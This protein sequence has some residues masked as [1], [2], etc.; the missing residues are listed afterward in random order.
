MRKRI[1]GARI[2]MVLTGLVLSLLAVCGIVAIALPDPSLSDIG[3]R[4]DQIAA[5]EKG[6][7]NFEFAVLSDVQKGLGSFRTLGNSLVKAD[8]AV[9]TGDMVAED[10]EEHWKLFLNFVRV[11]PMVAV[12]GNHDIEQGWNRFERFFGPVEF[13][14]GRGSCRFVGLASTDLGPFRSASFLERELAAAKEPNR[15]LFLHVPPFDWKQEGVVPRPGWEPF[16][17]LL[18][19]HRV[20]YVFCGHVHECRRLEHRGT[21][22]LL[23]GLGGDYESW[24]WNTKVHS[25]RVRVRGESVHLENVVLDPVH[26]VKSN[27]QHLAVGHVSRAFRQKP[28]LCWGGTVLLLAGLVFSIVVLLRLRERVVSS[29]EG[30]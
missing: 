25:M 2:A 11:R 10:D 13:S 23:N 30:A 20:Q 27:L 26:D 18:E 6:R 21:T 22:F 9:H 1:W 3:N 7:S 15:F 19:R 17:E 14:F 12:P 24:K 29:A 8:F 5:L 28:L 4:P 16:F